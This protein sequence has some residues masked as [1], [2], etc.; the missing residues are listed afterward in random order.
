MSWPWRLSLNS[1]ESRPVSL[2]V[3]CLCLSLVSLM[4]SLLLHFYYRPGT[5]LCLHPSSNKQLQSLRPQGI[6]P[7]PVLTLTIHKPTVQVQSQ[8]VVRPCRGWWLPHWWNQLQLQVFIW[9]FLSFFL[10]QQC[11][12]IWHVTSSCYLDSIANTT[13]SHQVKTNI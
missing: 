6:H 7:P 9:S 2:S 5:C 4:K 10:R 1:A 11:E 8:S 13:T 3:P 12:T